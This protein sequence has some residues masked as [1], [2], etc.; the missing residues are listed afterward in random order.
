[1]TDSSDRSRRRLLVATVVVTALVG[2]AVGV[3]VGGALR[4]DDS[5]S[6]VTLEPAT[7]VGADPFGPSVQVGPAVGLSDAAAAVAAATRAALPVDRRTHVRVAA[8]TTP[9]LYGGSGDERVCDPAQLVEFLAANQ[10]KAAAWA[11]VLRIPVGSIASYVARLTPVVL[12]ADTLV[13]NHGYRDGRATSLQSVLQAGTA[14]MVD[15]RGAPRVKCNCGNPLTEPNVVAPTEVRGVRWDGYDPTDVTVIHSG[16]TL[17]GITLVDIVTGGTYQQLLPTGSDDAGALVGMYTLSTAPGRC[18]IADALNGAVLGLLP[19][20]TGVLGG[21]GGLYL[22]PSASSPYD[23]VLESG[24]RTLSLRFTA[25]SEGRLSGTYSFDGGCEHSFTAR[26]YSSTVTPGFATAPTQ[27]TTPPSTGVTTTPSTHVPSAP[28]LATRDW[29]NALYDDQGCGSGRPVMLT[30]GRYVKDTGANTECGMEIAAVDFADIT[31]DGVSEVIVT[32]SAFA[33][34][35]KPW[36]WTAVFVARPDG[37]RNIGYFDG[38]AFPPYSTSGGVTLWVARLAETDPLC[39]PSLQE[40]TTYTY[41][42]T[43]GTLTPG[44]T[45]VVAAGERPS[46]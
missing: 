22:G 15:D 20:L 3:I 16:A 39:C 11:E 7:T 30:N 41:S 44:A 33:E 42:A 8:A 5:P 21:P 27:S 14:V 17:V 19:T 40:R 35:A 6:V 38:A 13:T 31:G 34:N 37:P 28:S 46:R 1:M 9:G 23:E 32:G 29:R 12:T 10:G 18:P 2:I 26:R 45:A 24:T 43:T 25:T 36:E 4:G